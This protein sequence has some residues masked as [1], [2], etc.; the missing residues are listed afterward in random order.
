VLRKW[1]AF[2]GVSKPLA[3]RVAAVRGEIPAASME[4]RAEGLH[5]ERFQFA[6]FIAAHPLKKIIFNCIIAKI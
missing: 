6:Y 2:S 4:V 3:H 1:R 5:G